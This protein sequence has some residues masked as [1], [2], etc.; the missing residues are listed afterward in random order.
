MSSALEIDYENDKNK[1]PRFLDE[2]IRECKFGNKCRKFKT[3][4]C[5]YYHNG[6]LNYKKD[7]INY[8]TS[9]HITTLVGCKF[10]DKCRNFKNN[11][12]NYF[13]TF[14]NLNFDYVVSHQRCPASRLSAWIYG[15]YKRNTKFI[16]IGRGETI[17][18]EIKN[19]MEFG[20]I[21]F[22]DIL[23]TKDDLE[24]LLENAK[25]IHIID[26]HSDHEFL[27][28][29]K[30]SN[31]KLTTLLD[32][33]KISAIL[34]WE[35]LYKDKLPWFINIANAREFRTL[36]DI[37]NGEILS[38]YLR[39]YGIIR[40]TR[41]INLLFK[42]PY[43]IILREAK[44]I[45]ESQLVDIKIISND[46]KDCLMKI[47][48]EIFKVKAIK[49]CKYELK[50]D[51]MDYILKQNKDIQIVVYYEQCDNSWKYGL[52]SLGKFDIGELVKKYNGHGD[53]YYG[54][55]HINNINFDEHGI[56]EFI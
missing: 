31:P 11:K 39:K 46:Y 50:N 32:K 40:Y 10:G 23:P 30:F 13:H 1:N 33:S 8:N 25:Q 3:R 18:D 51:S 38:S 55:F 21:L 37:T 35:Y 4:Q 44:Q 43:H 17:L 27:N 5:N 54:Y 48:D 47:G 6:I 24:F 2:S 49:N 26:N 19:D 28:N 9:K 42:T 16:E 52:R 29:P 12:C 14:D 15:Q 41:G 7:Q 45:Y 36:D 22:L 34:T 56:L 20:K 53:K